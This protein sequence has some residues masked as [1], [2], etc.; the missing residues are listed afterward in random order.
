MDKKLLQ[1]I[2]DSDISLSAYISELSGLCKKGFFI[3]LLCDGVATRKSVVKLLKI[4]KISAKR[5]IFTFKGIIVVVTKKYPQYYS[6]FDKG[7]YL[8]QKK[9]K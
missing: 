7:I 8:C 1:W 4:N 2:F 5:G 9:K 3:F 6:Y